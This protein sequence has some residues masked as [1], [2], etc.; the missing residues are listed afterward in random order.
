VVREQ[1]A[2]IVRA[3]E[4][5][6]F[7]RVEYRLS[8]E[9][10]NDPVE[11][12]RR[13]FI[14]SFMGFGSNALCRASKSGFRANSNRSGT[15]P[16]RDWRNYPAALVA[17]IERLRGVIIENRKA[18]E[19]MQHHDGPEVLHYV[20]PPYLHSTRTEYSGKGARSGYRFE[21]SEEDHRR[22]ADTL[23]SLRGHVVLSGYPSD[24][25]DRK[26][27]PTWRRVERVALADGAR[28][29]TEV[30]WM[31]FVMEGGKVC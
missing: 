22:L 11:Q 3:L 6:P 12:A 10:S 25:Y 26:L 30:L 7:S 18:E 14:R 15:T 20:D 29:R 4:L 16:A 21:M 28:K 1:E 23:H 17:T 27:Y 2:A 9:P 13:T 31:N 24:L 8:F 19:V 5:T